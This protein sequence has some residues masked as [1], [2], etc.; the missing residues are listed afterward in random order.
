[1]SQPSNAGRFVWRELITPATDASASFYTTLFHWTAEGMSMG[2]GFPYTM[3]NL[4]EG[5][6]GGM[7]VPMMEGIPPQWMAYITVD[8][9][10]AARARVIELGGRAFTECMDIPGIGRFAAVADPSGAAFAVF[11]SASPGASDSEGPPPAGTWCW[12]QLMAHDLAAAGAFYS[13]IFGWEVG[14]MGGMVVFNRNG[15]TVASAAPAMEGG[16]SAWLS[17]VAV[18]SCQ[19]GFEAA[20]AAGAKTLMGPTA[21]PGMGTFAVLADP[22]GAVFAIWQDQSAAQ[23]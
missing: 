7:T 16:P 2:E 15:V 3:F 23:A 4:G 22:G 18:D 13:G 17:Y 6:V 5:Q 8:D 14:E 19:T 10:D 20:V 21:M 12:S 9:A 1:M 11:Q